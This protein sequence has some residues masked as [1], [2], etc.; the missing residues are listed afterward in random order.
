MEFRTIVDIQDPGFRI[1]PCEEILFVGS[2]FAESIGQR[3]RQE[4]F[5]VTINPFGT[6]YNPASILHTIKRLET[7]S[8][9]TAFL[10]LGTNHVYRLKET[11]EIVDNCQKRPQSLFTEEELTVDEC[12]A[13]LQQAVAVLRQMNPQMHIVLTVSPIRYRKYGYH[14]S[15]LSK[16]TLLLAADR[17]P[18]A[19]F[20]AYELIC[21]ELRDYRFYASDMLHPSAQAVD[22]IWERLVEACFSPE[23]KTFLEEWRPVRQALGHKPFNPDSKEYIRFQEQAQQKLRALQK[24]YPKLNHT[25]IK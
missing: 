5:P 9:Q 10:T 14:G 22:Y 2:C 3:F 21:D 7:G 19:Y 15:Q 24:K 6:M 12:A 8:F 23:A 17:I 4:G 16:A 1:M 13:Y 18:V 20:P 25:F 11:G